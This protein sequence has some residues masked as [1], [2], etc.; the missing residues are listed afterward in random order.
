[1]QE[2][3]RISFNAYLALKGQNPRKGSGIKS[4]VIA[5]SRG[6]LY[7]FLEW[8]SKPG[9]G[10]PSTREKLTPL[11]VSRYVKTFGQLAMIALVTVGAFFQ[12][13]CA[14]QTPYEEVV[15]RCERA[16]YQVAGNP[17]TEHLMDAEADVAASRVLCLQVTDAKQKS[18]CDAAVDTLAA[19][20]AKTYGGAR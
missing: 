9:V 13:G 16:A 4:V 14:K 2:L 20:I 6:C 19:Q 12:T 3:R 15:G 17:N 1:M 11:Q 10:D 18:T 5:R 7:T 8:E